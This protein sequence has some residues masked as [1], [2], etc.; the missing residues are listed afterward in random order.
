MP[1]LSILAL[2]VVS[3]PAA[4]GQIERHVAASSG[5]TVLVGAT[6]PAGMQLTFYSAKLPAIDGST[7]RQ[8]LNIFDKLEKTLAKQGLT[9]RDVVKINVSLVAPPGQ[10]RPDY[11]G[12]DRAYRTRFG[13]AAQPQLV[14]QSIVQVTGLRDPHHLVAIEVIAASAP[15]ASR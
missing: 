7:E 13:T 12:F 14:A 8:A 9:F 3:A 15:P 10:T 4:A 1:R 5:A 2:L 6:V 11:D